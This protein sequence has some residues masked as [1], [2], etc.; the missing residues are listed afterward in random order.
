MV[1]FDSLFRID[2]IILFS[3]SFYSIINNGCHQIQFMK[4]FINSY[5]KIIK[6]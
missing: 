5:S 1:L 6:I 2:M 3:F 4:S